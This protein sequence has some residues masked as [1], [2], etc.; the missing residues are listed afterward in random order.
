MNVVNKFSHTKEIKSKKNFAF[1]TIE[2]MG[3]YYL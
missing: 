1:A 3:D 2:T